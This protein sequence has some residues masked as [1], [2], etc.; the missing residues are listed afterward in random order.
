MFAV[1]IKI[2][3]VMIHKFIIIIIVIIQRLFPADFFGS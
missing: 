3:I 1:E 2:I